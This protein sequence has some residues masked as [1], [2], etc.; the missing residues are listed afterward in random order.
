RLGVT[1]N[2]PHFAQAK[3]FSRRLCARAM[4]PPSRKARRA[5]SGRK[6]KGWG[7]GFSNRY[8][9]FANSNSKPKKNRKYDADKRGHDL[10]TIGR[11]VALRGSCSVGVPPQLSPKGVVVPK[12]QLQ[13]R[14]P[15]TRSD[16]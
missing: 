15:G 10:R 2:A 8:A 11:G 16:A 12:A 6:P 5:G 9:V 13:A 3:S 1:G 4:P 7:P 14:F